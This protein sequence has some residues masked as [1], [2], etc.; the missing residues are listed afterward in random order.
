MTLESASNFDQVDGII[1]GLSDPPVLLFRENTGPSRILGYIWKEESFSIFKCHCGITIPEQSIKKD[2]FKQKVQKPH[3]SP[4][5]KED[6]P[7]AASSLKWF[8]SQGNPWQRSPTGKSMGANQEAL[9][10]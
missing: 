4:H 2:R 3:M 5:L 9:T 6:H 10:S 8:N 7:I 1:Y